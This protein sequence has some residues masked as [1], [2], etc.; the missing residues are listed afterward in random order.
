MVGLGDQA[1]VSV[2]QPLGKSE[3]WYQKGRGQEEEF[4]GLGQDRGQGNL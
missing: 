2:R 1:R 4:Q 3:R